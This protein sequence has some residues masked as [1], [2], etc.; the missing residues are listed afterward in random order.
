MRRILTCAVTGNITRPD[1]TPYLPISPKE[2]ADS[3]LDAAE[4]GAAIVHIHVRH[5][6]SGKP[7]MDL[8]HYEEVVS[9]IRD[10]NKT[11][12]INLTTGP[13]GRFVPH[14]EDPK[15][16]AEGTTLCHPLR[17]VEHIA[18]LRPDICSLDLN[19]M[20]SGQ[21]VVI[22]T[23]G[24]V[25]KMAEVINEGLIKGPAL[26]TF[27]MG[28]KYGLNAHPRTLHFITQQLPV[29]AHWAAFGIGRDC[30][31]ILAQ[32]YLLG[33]HIRVGLE[34]NIYLSRGN[35]AKSN[36]EL[37]FKGRQII[38]SLG[39]ELASSKEARDLLNL[40]NDNLPF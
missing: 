26:F 36:A 8:S 16:Y 34:D 7:S 25:R 35:L 39:G 17:R 9:R 27:V 18:A 24:N 29:D 38:E 30:Y 19:T 4:A 3:C 11:L 20:N 21:Q 40:R 6:E 5:P 32:A 14:E 23:P 13:G 37:V 31:P 10:K 2:I 12:V 15:S 22:N 28:V 1:Q 33:G